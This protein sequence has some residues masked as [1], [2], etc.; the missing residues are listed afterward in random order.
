MERAESTVIKIDLKINAFF[1]LN[2]LLQEIK[3]A[4]KS[5][6]VFISIVSEII[7]FNIRSKEFNTRFYNLIRLSRKNNLLLT[8]RIFILGMPSLELSNHIG[9]V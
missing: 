8:I 2:F 3:S 9:Q 5:S 1:Y 6:I 7:P 4:M